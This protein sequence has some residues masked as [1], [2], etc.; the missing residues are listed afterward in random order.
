MRAVTWQGRRKVSV[1]NVPDPII[2]EPTDAVIRVTSTNICGSDLHLYETL[3]AFMS[4]GDII[5]HE[6]MGVVEEVGTQTG[7]LKV[8]DR[9]VIPFNISCGTCW[10]CDHGLQS[11]CETTQNRDQG[12]GAALFG[13]SKLYGEVAGGQAEYLRVPQAQYTH[14]KIPEDGPD[15]RFVYLSD[16]L[17]TAWQGVEYANVP[18]GGTL[19]VVGLGPIGSMACRIAAH[20]NNCRVI[21]IDLVEE[22]LDRA[23]PYCAEVIDLRTQ[24][25]DAVVAELTQG[26]G[27]DSVIDAVGME[28]HGSPVAEAAQTA[29]GFLP[30][31][32]GRVVMKHAGV[33]RLAALNSAIALVRR[34]GTVSL[35]GVYGG[36]AD[37][38]NMMTLFDK[39]VTLRMGQANVK[40]WVP[41]I[42]PLLTA[43]DPLGVENFATHR[44]PLAEAPG[45]YET[46]QK[47]QDGMV[48]VVLTP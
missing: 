1:D 6:A 9:V 8:G 13:F 33:D 32:I 28:A 7:D 31:S 12:T 15:E 16:V 38:I 43:D 30:S 48:K 42:L 14:I 37:P 36:A 39:Q 47:K 17:P 45:A 10:M 35:S 4:P 34:G 40:R 19:V 3:S 24:D 5:G 22:R 2:K 46:F 25:A 20:R 23:R 11:Q 44:L 29:S 27:A 21:G 26:R 41:D 18:D